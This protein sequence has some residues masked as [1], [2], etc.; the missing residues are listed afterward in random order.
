MSSENE[1]Y[2]LKLSDISKW[3]GSVP[4]MEHLERKVDSRLDKCVTRTLTTRAVE[5]SITHMIP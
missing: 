4:E 5:R 2:S 1:D 3:K